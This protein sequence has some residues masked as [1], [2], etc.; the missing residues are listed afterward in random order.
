MKSEKDGHVEEVHRM[1]KRSLN[2]VKRNVK[3][4]G[5]MKSKSRS[6]GDIKKTLTA[7]VTVADLDK[8]F[9]TPAKKKKGIVAM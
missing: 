3:F 8:L 6:L 5:L 2:R 7:Q 4:G 9:G 1:M